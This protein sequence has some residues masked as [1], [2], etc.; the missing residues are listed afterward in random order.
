M[1]LLRQES[2]YQGLEIKMD[3][4]Y[5]HLSD[6][7]LFL[8]MSHGDKEAYGVLYHRYQY[9]GNQCA[10]AMIRTNHLFDYSSYDFSGSIDDSIDR[11]FRYYNGK[12]SFSHFCKDLITQSLSREINEFITHNAARTAIYLD[13][14]IS[15]DGLDYH[16]IIHNPNELSIREQYNYT[17]FIDDKLHV[18]DPKMRKAL[19]IFQL[20]FIGYSIQEIARKLNCSVYDVRHSLKEVLDYLKDEHKYFH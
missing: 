20:K 9:F 5:S 14:Q 19:K 7:E 12:D 3:L 4:Y 13:S 18:S 11:A 8:Q 17:Q 2:Y 10:A 6:E 16:E 15:E 1:S